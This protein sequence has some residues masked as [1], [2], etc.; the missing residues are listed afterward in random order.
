M[1]FRL[2]LSLVFLCMKLGYA[3][4]PITILDEIY[5]ADSG[6]NPIDLSKLPKGRGVPLVR[7]HALQLESSDQG[8]EIILYNDAWAVMFKMKFE[9][10]EYTKTIA[11]SL[12]SESGRKWLIENVTDK[13]TKRSFAQ[14]S[15]LTDRKASSFLARM[16]DVVIKRG[17]DLLCEL[18]EMQVKSEQ[19]IEKG[20]EII[21]LY[22]NAIEGH[23]AAA[24]FYREA[25]KGYGIAAE[26]YEK[27]AEMF[28]QVGS[29][30]LKWK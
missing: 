2:L 19:Q 3:G 15:D 26:G 29:M 14:V 5:Y 24:D 21:K 12:G 20:K 28:E 22:E 17:N 6:E 25:A 8:S 4:E 9:D 30:P 11:D 13:K 7:L 27:A 16:Y 1:S 18:E 10:P 23:K